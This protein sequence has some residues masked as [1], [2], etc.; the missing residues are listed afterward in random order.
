MTMAMMLMMMM[1]MMALKDKNLV[2]SEA[3][4]PRNRTKMEPSSV[5]EFLACADINLSAFCSV[6]FYLTGA[7]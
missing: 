3:S 4:C 6:V 1:M 7:N 2:N 5:N